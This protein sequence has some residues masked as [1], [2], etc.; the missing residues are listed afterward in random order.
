MKRRINR[1]KGAV[2]RQIE[3]CQIMSKQL[4]EGKRREEKR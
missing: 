1:K 3:S 2:K 4:R